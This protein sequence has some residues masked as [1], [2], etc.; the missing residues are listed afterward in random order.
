MWP[1]CQSQPGNKYTTAKNRGVTQ[2]ILTDLSTSPPL[3][4]QGVK[5]CGAKN[6]KSKTIA[7]SADVRVLNYR[8]PRAAKTPQLLDLFAQLGPLKCDDWK[9]GYIALAQP[10][11]DRLHSNFTRWY[12]VVPG[13]LRNCEKPLRV[14]FKMA[15]D[16]PIFNIRTPIS[17][18]RLKLDLVCA[19]TTSSN[20]NGMHKLGQSGRDPV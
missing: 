4:L 5:K 7:Y 8:R 17:L 3:F 1:N 2:I 18:E 14:K 20:F 13:K 11:V 9:N 19:S 15:D 16:A 10:P 12:S 6:Q